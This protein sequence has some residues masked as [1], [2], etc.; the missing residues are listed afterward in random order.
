MS[1]FKQGYFKPTNPEKYKGNVDKI[2]YR[3]SWELKFNN[4]CDKHPS[5]LEWSSEEIVIPYKKPTDNQMHRY[6]LGF[7]IFFLNSG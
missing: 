5:V 4:W 2:F 6:F 3:S 7:Q 1:R